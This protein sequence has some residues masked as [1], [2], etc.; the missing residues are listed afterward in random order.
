MLYLDGAGRPLSPLYTWEDG[1]GDQLCGDGRTYARLLSDLT[2]WPMATGYGLTT[3]FYNRVHGLVPESAAVCCTIMDYIAMR[4]CGRKRPLTHP[5]NA[6]SFGL[7]SLKTMDFDPAALAAAGMD[8]ELLPEV[9]RGEKLIGAASG[10]GVTLPIGDN[11]AGI[12]GSVTGDEDTVLNIGTSCQISRICREKTAPKGLELRPYVGGKTVMLGAGL[13]GGSAFR[14]L[15]GFFRQA[16]AATG[17]ELSEKAMFGC[18][19]AWAREARKQQ[20]PLRVSP[21]FRGT[22]REPALRGSVENMS[23][24]NFT[25]GTLS[26]AFFRGVLE[27]MLSAYRKMPPAETAV[28]LMLSG[29]ALR[30]NPLLAELAAETFGCEVFFTPYPEEAAMGAAMLAAIAEA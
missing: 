28:R 1:R 15:N 4:L 13:C 18:M 21:L 14:L 5:T 17:T 12:L 3:M 7:F 29:N 10:L 19:T 11:Q 9:V 27:E 25:P 26:L 6:D 20:D 22:R 8:R 30:N 23:M 16:C 2:G 24:D